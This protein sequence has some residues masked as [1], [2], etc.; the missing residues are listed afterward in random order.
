MQK[1]FNY[2]LW[3][4]I[5][6]YKIQLTILHLHSFIS[7]GFGFVKSNEAEILQNCCLCCQD[8]L[9][10]HHSFYRI[11]CGTYWEFKLPKPYHLIS[12]GMVIIILFIK[13]LSYIMTSC[14]KWKK[15][16]KNYFKL[17]HVAELAKCDICINIYIYI[18][19]YIML[20]N[21]AKEVIIYCYLTLVVQ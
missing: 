6:T 17:F 10:R 20:K 18:H 19:I 13:R 2:F 4:N 11:L 9:K 7:R 1:R 16:Y 21:I 5:Y 3:L 12:G 14:K 15:N 8:F